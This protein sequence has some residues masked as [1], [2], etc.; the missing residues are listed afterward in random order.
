VR[1]AHA[2]SGACATEGYVSLKSFFALA[3][4]ALCFIAP[5]SMALI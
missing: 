1:A 5:Q 3:L 2:F 4:L